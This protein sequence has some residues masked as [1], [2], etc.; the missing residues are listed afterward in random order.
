MKHEEDMPAPISS[1]IDTLMSCIRRVISRQMF[2]QGQRAI[3]LF[4][5]LH[6][7]GEI[8]VVGLGL[9][10]PMITILPIYPVNIRCYPGLHSENMYIGKMLET[11]FKAMLY[12]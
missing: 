9:R 10:V 2:D 6:F 5:R 7:M 1:I 3:L 12:Q 4:F 11:F 8:Q